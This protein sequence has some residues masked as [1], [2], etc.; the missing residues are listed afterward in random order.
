MHFPPDTID[1]MRQLSWLAD[2]TY[3]P[4]TSQHIVRT[5]FSCPY[6]VK[7]REKCHAMHACNIYIYISRLVGMTMTGLGLGG[8]YLKAVL[9][10]AG[11]DV[12]EIDDVARSSCHEVPMS[13]LEPHLPVCSLK[14]TQFQNLEI[15]KSTSCSFSFLIRDPLIPEISDF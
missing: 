14:F 5:S 13:R 8:F 6:I 7:P 15:R 9:D 4:H 11:F 3:S 2:T 12:D 1:H 10:H